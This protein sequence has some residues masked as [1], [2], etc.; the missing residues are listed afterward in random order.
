MRII[1]KKLSN[2][3]FTTLFFTPKC[4]CI[5]LRNYQNVFSFKNNDEN[6]FPLFQTSNCL[7]Q[8]GIIYARLFDRR[9]FTDLHCL[10]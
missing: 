6:L 7:M 1:F 4:N 8:N 9:T 3:T 5:N 2:S 10:S